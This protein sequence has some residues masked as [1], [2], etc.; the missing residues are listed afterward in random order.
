MFLWQYLVQGQDFEADQGGKGVGMDVSQGVAMEVKFLEVNQV[1]KFTP[2]QVCQEVLLQVENSELSEA[3]K[4]LIRDS[5]DPWGVKVELCQVFPADELV[6]N[7]GVSR[8]HVPIQVD[9]SGVHGDK[10]RDPGV[11]PGPTSDD[12][13]GPCGIME[14]VTPI[15][16]LHPAV[17]GKKVTAHAQ[18]ETVSLILAHEFWKRPMI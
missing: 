10:L 6:W 3:A 1:R 8:Q 9:S 17:T 12:V 13:S 4:G 11:V 5:L 15:R 14:A 18:S 2:T 7:E 16:A